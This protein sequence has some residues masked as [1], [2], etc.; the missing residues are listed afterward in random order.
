MTYLL[1]QH[2]YCQSGGR[3]I[4]FLAE[5]AARPGFIAALKTGRIE[6][7]PS[8]SHKVDYWCQPGCAKSPGPPQSKMA[9]KDAHPAF[10]IAERP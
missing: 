1:T 7:I 6:G 8:D 9:F 2:P 5:S 3:C 4:F 10:E